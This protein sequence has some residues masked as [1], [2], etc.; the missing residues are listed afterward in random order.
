MFNL[1]SCQHQTITIRNYIHANCTLP[2]SCH[3]GGRAEKLCGKKIP[4]PR[5]YITLS[6]DLPSL[7]PVSREVQT[8]CLLFTPSDLKGDRSRLLWWTTSVI[9]SHKF[10]PS[11]IL[12]QQTF[13]LLFAVHIPQMQTRWRCNTK[14]SSSF[15]NESP[16]AW[17]GWGERDAISP[18]WLSTDSPSVTSQKRHAVA[19]EL[20]RTLANRGHRRNQLPLK[21]G[22][23]L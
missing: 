18:S 9:K 14:P 21:R 7:T 16:E 5:D 23:A 15:A 12:A 13:V 4:T 20:K 3:D 1:S 8:K 11:T 22:D 6:C 17:V 2:F 10:R 19:A